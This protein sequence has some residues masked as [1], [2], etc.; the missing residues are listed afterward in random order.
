M[1]DISSPTL[2][3][4]IRTRV[5]DVLGYLVPLFQSIPFVYAGFM[6]APFVL[7]LLGLIVT[8]PIALPAFVFALVFG[9]FPLELVISVIG[10][11]LL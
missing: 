10:F 11:F 5:L 9:G 4:R 3:Q 2:I 8:S 7:Y 6:S 1:E